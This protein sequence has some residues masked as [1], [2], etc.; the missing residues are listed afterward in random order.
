MESFNFA[1]GAQWRARAAFACVALS[2]AACTNACGQPVPILMYHSVSDL[3]DAYAVAEKDFAA[4]LDYLKSA[5]FNTVTLHEL[6]EHE[7]HKAKLAAHPIVLTFDDGYQDNYSRAFPLLKARGMRAT[8]FVVTRFMGEDEAH[9]RVEDRGGPRE[10]RYLL[11]S[12]VREMAAA[13]ME[14]G[15]HSL[16]HKRLP[17]LSPEQIKEDVEKSRQELSDKLSAPVEFFAYPFNSERRHIRKIVE[18]GGYRGA[19]A[20]ARSV[21][22]RFELARFGVYRGMTANDLRDKLEENWTQ[23]YTTDGN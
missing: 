4:Q 9:R 15:S 20:G 11:W 23:S 14:I 22:D 1:Q 8:F 10:R 17:D 16:M 7:D 6:V 18:A 13:G 5:G 21:G 12:E 2:L 19:V 3:N